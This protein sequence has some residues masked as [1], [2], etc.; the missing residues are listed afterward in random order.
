MQ[1]ARLPAIAGIATLRRPSGVASTA[2][3]DSRPDT[4][5]VL[6]STVIHRATIAL[7][8]QETSVAISSGVDT[9]SSTSNAQQAHRTTL[10][11][12]Y[13]LS[14]PPRGQRAQRAAHDVTRATSAVDT[15]ATPRRRCLA[16]D[17]SGSLS[18]PFTPRLQSATDVDV[19]HTHGRMRLK[20]VADAF[21]KLQAM[22]QR[23]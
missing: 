21:R 4:L 8:A 6:H 10:T 14:F 13:S 5:S 3:A 22:Q 1:V 23:P 16:G 18:P 20:R 9:A 19:N 15:R 2:N 17:V 7:T 11:L 12:R